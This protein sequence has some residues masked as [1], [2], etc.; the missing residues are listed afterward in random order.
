MRHK[1]ALITTESFRDYFQEVFA[2]LEL[3]CELSIHI[4]QSFD[5]IAKIYKSLASDTDGILTSGSFPTHVLKKSVENIPIPICS[6][7]NDDA[8]L[9]RTWFQILEEN[10]KI[11]LSRVYFE[12]SEFLGM[13][14]KEYLLN[15]LQ[16]SYSDLIDPVVEK[17]ELSDLYNIEQ[18]QKEKQLKL[19]KAGAI[20]VSVTRF[21]SIV[22]E[23]LEA[24]VK[25]YLP[26]PSMEYVKTSCFMLLKEVDVIQLKKHLPAAIHVTIF[27]TAAKEELP[28]SINKECLLLQE[29]LLEFNGNS[30]LDYAIERVHSGFEVL[31]ERDKVRA[32]TNQYTECE[33]KDFLE[34]RLDFTVCVGYGIGHDLY[35]ARIHAVNANR[36]S[37]LHKSHASF[38]IDERETLIGPL[39]KAT[40]AMSTMVLEKKEK[41]AL[42]GVKLASMTVRRVLAAM[43][44]M[45]N[46][47]ITAG[48]LALK[49]GITRRSSNRFLTELER[50]SVVYVSEMKTP[51]TKGR[52]ERVYSLKE[53]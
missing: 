50:G 43:R 46:R 25:V 21:S 14:A 41:A 22:P 48:E 35:Q 9:Y 20:D 8:S 36:E 47:Q 16:V 39:G 2:E 17:M 52:P 49:L 44:Q 23:L 32:H 45:P 26:K 38:L 19:W 13:H 11:D 30:I 28:N 27:H 4:Y 3:V 15:D 24:G 33:L 37:L 1:I 53:D 42:Q 10:P 5:E 7:N 6:I 12:P 34:Q 31:V 51:I 40:T 18:Q 29:A